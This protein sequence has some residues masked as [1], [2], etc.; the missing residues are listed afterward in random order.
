MDLET[1]LA[2][3]D[4]AAKYLEGL[5]TEIFKLQKE[6][7][8]F[9]AGIETLLKVLDVC[10]RCR[11]EKEYFQRSCAE[12]EGEVRLCPRCNGSGRYE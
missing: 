10:P 2:V 5:N 12:D 3:I 11:G 9:E 4:K 8:A 6:K 7:E 1:K